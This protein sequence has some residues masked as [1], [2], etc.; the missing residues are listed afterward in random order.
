MSKILKK[1]N[2]IIDYNINL[3][4][5]HKF[6][7]ELYSNSIIRQVVMCNYTYC[8]ECG[9]TYNSEYSLMTKKLYNL[10]NNEKNEFKQ[11]LENK[12]MTELEK[13]TLKKLRKDFYLNSINTKNKQDNMYKKLIIY[14][15]NIIF[16]TIFII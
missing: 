1:T 15:F 6:S 4:C 11:L 5:G 7:I 9:D 14:I 12:S 16:D 3:P 13:S 2:N 10:I 8:I